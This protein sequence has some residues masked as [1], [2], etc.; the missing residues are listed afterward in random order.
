M[1]G[2][3]LLNV[4]TTWAQENTDFLEN[5][6]AMLFEYHKVVVDAGVPFESLTATKACLDQVESLFK[7]VG[8][9]NG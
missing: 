4:A 9:S 7:A 5:F 2:N 3:Q 8:V 6:Q 1:D